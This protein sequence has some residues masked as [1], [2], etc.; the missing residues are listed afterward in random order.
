MTSL[1]NGV[2]ACG[3]KEAQV[4]ER[5]EAGEPLAMCCVPATGNVFLIQDHPNYRLYEALVPGYLELGTEGRNSMKQEFAE[6][7]G[8]MKRA[9][10]MLDEVIKIRLG[11][12]D[13]H[14]SLKMDVAT[15]ANRLLR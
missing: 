10:E 9:M 1:G 2:F 13:R 6:G 8:A 3:I 5:N 14:W 7:H 15:L 4:P 11:R 12:E